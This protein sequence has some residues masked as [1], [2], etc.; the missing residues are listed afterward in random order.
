MAGLQVGVQLVLGVTPPVVVE[1]VDLAAKVL[2]RVL[3]GPARAGV[4]PVAAA[5][6]DVVPVAVDEVE[7]LGRDLAVGSVEALLIG[8]AAQHAETGLGDCGAGGRGRLRPPRGGSL[9]A[10]REAVEIL[11]AGLQPRD[12]DMHRMAELGSGDRLAALRHVGKAAI[13]CDFPPDRHRSR[14]HAVADLERAG[15]EPGPYDEAV[16]RRVAGGDA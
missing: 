8:L 9:D 15:G 5:F 3:D 14:G 16:G 10:G 7:V 13:R 11:A 12:L 6:V 2:A 1:A 4:G